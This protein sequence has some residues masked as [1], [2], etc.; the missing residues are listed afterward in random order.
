[1]SQENSVIIERRFCGPPN[2]GNGGY[3]CGLMAQFID[4]AANVTLRSPPPLERA[5]VIESVHP[6]K[7]LL[8]DGETIVAEAGPTQLE[9]DVPHPPTYAQAQAAAGR[10]LGFDQHPFPTCF[11]CG[12]ERAKSDGLRIFPGPLPGG[13][14]MMVAAPW[15]LADPDGGYVRPEFLWAALDCPGY[16][17]A[18]DGRRRPMVLGRMVARIEGRIRPGERCV[19]FGWP[20]SRDGR[21]GYAG[22][23][24]YSEAGEPLGRAKTT[25]IEVV[26]I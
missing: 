7:L 2:S 4:G 22:T 12:P 17:A 23:A 19:V 10:Y 1:L 11:V 18:L 6:D 25:W 16:F 24:L 3:V 13:D 20:I 15:A 5:L 26:W 8:R 21:K 14:A 9:L